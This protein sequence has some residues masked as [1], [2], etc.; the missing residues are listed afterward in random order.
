MKV[1]N[2]V[3]DHF[4]VFTTFDQ[5]RLPSTITHRRSHAVTL[6]WIP[7]LCSAP[8]NE[9]ADSGKGGHDK[10]N[11]VSLPATLREDHHQGQATQVEA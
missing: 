11:W 10:R 8:G 7:S 6:Q 1:I 2:H 4:E 3:H 9:A 5:C